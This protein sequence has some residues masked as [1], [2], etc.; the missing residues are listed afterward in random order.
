M[1]KLRTTVRFAE[2]A[3]LTA[4]NALL[5]G[6]PSGQVKVESGALEGIEAKTPGVRAYLGI[7]YAAP[8]V[9]DLRWKAPQPAPAWSGAFKADHFGHRCMQN[10]VFDDM[11]FHDEGMSE[12][13]LH[14][15]VWTPAKSPN[16]KLAVMVWIYVGGFQA[17]A[18]SEARQNGEV[19]AGKGVVVV[20]MDYR[21]GIFGFYSHPE[22]S[23]ESGHHSSGNYGLMDQ[24]EALRWVHKNIAAFG[25]DPNKVTIF[26][27]SAGSFSVSAQMATPLSKGLIARAIGESGAFFGATLAAMA[28]SKTEQ[29]G[30]KFA[31]EQKAANLAEMR[32]I[33]AE[34]LLA[35]T[36]SNGF[37]FGPNVD[38]YFLPESATAIYSAGK[39]AHV[40]LIAGWNA[41]E[42]SFPAVMGKTTAEKFRGQ[43]H[44]KFPADEAQ[45]LKLYAAGTDAEGL[46]SAIDLASDQFI[47][48]GTWK[49]VELQRK[50]SGK[51]VYEYIFGRIRP[52]SPDNKING[53]DP[54]LFGAVHAS[55]IEYVFGALDSLK[56]YDWQPE[57][58]KLSDLIQ[59]YWSNFAKTGDPN[60]P[61][62]PKWPENTSKNGYAVMHLD[63]D[64]HAAP[65]AH[66]D[67]YEFLDSYYAR[68]PK[69][70]DST[71]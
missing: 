57:D 40:P 49:W 23:K 10:N 48:Y 24:L 25:G 50:T 64:A 11:V 55:E 6:A 51:P 13:C 53:M 54:K 29:D 7:P 58:R 36:K 22:L 27:E 32:A 44:D 1:P 52:P 15:N 34:K 38:G 5:M 21:L 4:F 37:R 45:L 68:P 26:G 19:L 31:T 12:D 16:E 59:S 46:E 33:P 67:R 35:A 43:I 8:P 42:M 28:V 71:K 17:G 69:P 63:V 61:G 30:A 66:R 62:L 9:G 2:L 3:L 60:G 65:A 39:Q 70:A 47:V 18:T 41:Q 56:G 14:L 20:S